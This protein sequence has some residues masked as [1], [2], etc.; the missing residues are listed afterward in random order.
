MARRRGRG[1]GSI[2]HRADGRWE[3]RVDLGR[4]LD[5]ERRQKSVFAETE[6]GAIRELKTLHGRSVA[7]HVLQTS[8]P[9]V[10]QYLEDWYATNMDTWRPST[11]RGYRGAI[12]GHLV[13][14]FGPLRLE[15]LTP[16]RIQRWL[17]EH[18]QAHGARRRIVLAH[19]VLRSA[20]ADA[21]RLQLVGVN[22]AEL[23]KVPTPK[24]RPIAPLTVA[25]ASAFLTAAEQHR[26]SALFSVALACGLRLGEAT[27]L[28]WE[29]VDLDA[30]EI[31]I[32][33]QLQVV[34]RRLIAQEL[35]T[36][37]SH[38]TLV[39]P[40]V[41]ITALRAHRTRQR[42]ERLKAGARW[43][44]SGLVFTTYRTYRD[45]KGAGFTVGAGL[46][47]RNVTRVLEAVLAA[48]HR[49]EA[50]LA[51]AHLP[52]VRF[53]DLRHSAASLL[54]ANGVELVE[55]SKLLGHSELRITSDLYT[56][57]VKETAAKAARLM[58]GLFGAKGC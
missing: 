58:D 32:R 26:L 36:A 31:R 19:A 30:G 14:A 53:H 24:A 51:A 4:G 39:L 22:A 46:H 50:V 25:Q 23:V 42:E 54:I 18:K 45:G 12:D 8:T 40:N 10:A 17:T 49:L 35:K 33:Q 9:T 1:E 13:P 41:C 2:R 38:R 34:N 5:G 21:R 43:I 27:G 16:P 47:P 56:H 55:V 6:A 28:R 57:L 7:G 20:L 44:D 11:R 15:H 48:A 37:K 29:D 52:H 3:A